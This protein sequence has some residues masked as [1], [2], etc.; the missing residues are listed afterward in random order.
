M[1]I[2]GSGVPHQIPPTHQADA[3]LN[4]GN[5]VSGTAYPVLAATNNVRIISI[6][7]SVTWTVQPNP[8][9]VHVTIDGNTI[10]YTVANPVSATYYFAR[11]AAALAETA[12]IL[13]TN[14]YSHY[15]AFLLEGKNVAITAE[16]TGGTTSNLA[17]RVKYAR[18]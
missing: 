10:T 1:G 6:A 13:D 18:W 5:P 14:Y 3:V 7:V 16:T 15:R 17:C 9:E 8:L 2:I 12:Q 4:Q 11:P